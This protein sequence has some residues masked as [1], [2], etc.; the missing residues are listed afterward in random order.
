MLTQLIDSSIEPRKWGFIGEERINV[1][2]LNL[3]LDELSL[4]Q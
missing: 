2:L 3:K 1:L 4:D